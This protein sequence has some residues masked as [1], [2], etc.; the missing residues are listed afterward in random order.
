MTSR[1]W[2]RVRQTRLGMLICRQKLG[3]RDD[4]Y[5]TAI[6]GKCSDEQLYTGYLKELLKC[7]GVIDGLN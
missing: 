7:V 4:V 3:S 6:L 1:C 2:A 5:H